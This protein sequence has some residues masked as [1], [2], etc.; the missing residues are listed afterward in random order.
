MNLRQHFK[1]AR[2][3]APALV[4]AL[5]LTA[6]VGQTQLRIR[7]NQ[8]D[9]TTAERQL[10]VDAL[11]AL[12]NP[13]TGPNRGTSGL[14]NRYDEYVQMHGDFCIHGNGGFLPWHRKLLW[15]FE[16]DVRAIAPAYANF[17]VPYWDWTVDAFPSDLTNVGDKLFMG[18]DG[19]AVTQIVD[20]GPFRGGQWATLVPATTNG[21]T[22]LERKFTA[23]IGTLITNGAPA[24]TNLLTQTDYAQ[25]APLVEGAAG[26]HNNAHFFVGGQLSD[27]TGGADDPVFF[28]LHS[29]TD[30]VWARWETGT[31]G[32]LSSYT[33]YG[34]SPAVNAS[35]R[36]FGVPANTIGFDTTTNNLVSG[37]LNFLDRSTLG[38]TYLYDGKLLGAPEPSSVAFL[39]AGTL[40][41]IGFGLRRR[42]RKLKAA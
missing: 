17:T 35:L 6:V 24:F 31:T 39:G 25:M 40:S 28:M 10:Y 13:A 14:T 1:P 4:T 8:K 38:Y 9:L 19:V 21:A 29:F 18:G 37:Q 32:S 5:L 42:H 2:L 27:T 30:L 11:K 36:G 12:K 33:A 22:S 23:N 20:T 15:E 3:L 41:L 16:N 7:K 26:M 34:A